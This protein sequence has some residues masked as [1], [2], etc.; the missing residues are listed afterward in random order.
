VELLGTDVS[1][2]AELSNSYRDAHLDP[3]DLSIIALAERL[4]ISQVATLD[5]RDFTIVRPRHCT[6][7]TLLP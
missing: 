3:T 4:Q 1:R 7:F 2:M 6:A 5:R